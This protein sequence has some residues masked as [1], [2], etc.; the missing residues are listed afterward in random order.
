MSTWCV[1]WVGHVVSLPLL[2]LNCSLRWEGWVGAAWVRCRAGR[3]RLL[4]CR[5][6]GDCRGRSSRRNRHTATQHARPHARTPAHT[7]TTLCLCAACARWVVRLVGWSIYLSI[8]SAHNNS[9]LLGRVREIREREP[10]PHARLQQQLAHGPLLPS[11]RQGPHAQ[12]AEHGG[13]SRAQIRAHT[14]A[15][16]S[17]VFVVGSVVAV[18]VVVVV[19]AG[20]RRTAR[21][22]GSVFCVLAQVRGSAHR[23]R[24]GV[25]HRQQQQQQQQRQE[26][27]MRHSV[28]RR[29]VV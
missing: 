16:Q 26:Q 10:A 9:A 7:R 13:H 28:R 3:L 24:G 4:R 21:A 17:P 29:R 12:G 20:A 19:V 1:S 25:S 23:C 22:A 18:V 11:R 27:G 2:L 8:Y 15:R 6:G 14:H 5:V